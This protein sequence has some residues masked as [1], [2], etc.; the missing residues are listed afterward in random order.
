M[1]IDEFITR[2]RK[3][4]N[5]IIAVQQGEVK[6]KAP[7][8]ALTAAIIEEIKQ[9][10]PA[11][12]EFYKTID[13][14]AGSMLIKQAEAKDYYQ[15]S[16][17]Q[18]RLY[19][20][21]RFDTESLAYNVPQV[22]KLTGSIDILKLEGVFKQLIL[23][24][25]ILRTYFDLINGE[26]V[27]KIAKDV[28]F[29]I[30]HFPITESEITDVTG[31]FVRPFDLGIAP[32]IR[33]GVIGTDRGTNLLMVDMHH[34]VTD[35]VSV[36][37]LSTD[38]MA[39]YSNQ[40]LPSLPLQYKD[41][42]EW[43]QSNE[44]KNE[45]EKQH[46]FWL[47]RFADELNTPELPIDF[48]RPA[49]KS[50]SGD[51]INFS[52]SARE[53]KQLKIIADGEDATL[54]MLLLS[55]FNVLLSKLCNQEDVIVGIPVA[56]RNHPALENLLGMFVNTLVLRNKADGHL[57][58]RQ[59]LAEVKR[60]TLACLDHQS[61]PYEDLI[62]Q[63]KLERE[64]SHNPLFDVMFSYQ[65][66]QRTSIEIPGLALEPWY[67]NKIISKFDITLTAFELED[68]VSLN[69]EYCTD[70]FKQ[71]TIEQFITYFKRIVSLVIADVDMKIS[72]IE[73]VSASERRQLLYDS[74]DTR[75]EYTGERNVTTLFE[76]RA[77]LNP[78]N[79]ALQLNGA[80]T[81]YRELNELSERIA[82]Y[83]QSVKAVKPGDLVG[84][85][86]EREMSLL[87]CLLAIWKAGAAYVPI[88]TS[89][90]AE[91]VQAIIKDARLKVVLTRGE[92]IRSLLELESDVEIIDL[93]KELPEIIRCNHS[94]APV[95]RNGNELAYVMYTSGS[96]GTPKGV[97]I[98]HRSLFNYINWA[99]Q[100]YTKG[101]KAGFA[102]YTSISFDLTV[103]SL[104]LPLITG[105]TLFIYPEKEHHLLIEEVLTEDRAS[106]IKLTPA[107]L[108]VIC[109][110]NVLK[111][112]KT[113]QSKTFIVGGEQLETSLAL[114]IFQKFDGRV[115]IFNEYG[116]TEATVGCMI[117]RFDPLEDRSAV[118]I[119]VPARNTSIYLL[120]KFLQ[121]VATGVQGEMYISGDGVAEGYYL[122]DALTREK[123]V[124]NPFVEGE[125]MYRTGDVAVRL[126]NGNIV[127]KGRMD[128][129][130][131]I[132][133]F[134]IEIGEIESRLK[135]YDA[136]EEAVVVATER[137]GDKCLVGYYVAE[138]EIPATLL[139]HFLTERLPEYM[140][141]A[142]FVHLLSL[143]L[144]ING[145][146]NK[147]ALPAPEVTA[148][149]DYV[150]AA[151]HIENELVE[152][153]ADILRIGKE[154]ISTRKSFFE[155]GG[156]SL[157]IIRL[158]AMIHDRLP[159][160]ITIPEL[161]RYPTIASLTDF[162][163]H[164]KKGETK[165]NNS[166]KEEI[167]GMEQLLSMLD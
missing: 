156:N 125:K 21:H 62:D 112:Y 84:V 90:P 50:F 157:K 127:Y 37:V 72:A 152:I 8:E 101:E 96:T 129:Q 113:S 63:L 58:F 22:F 134:R 76:N 24:H 115:E 161:F 45:R 144:T 83:L 151:G 4:H 102:L 149:E 107:H 124:D 141:P 56:G 133:G 150:A 69:M 122:N 103:T 88:D 33:I 160:Q 27:Q 38:F 11:I 71:E 99:A 41:Y 31:R 25:E 104:F 166:I 163:K 140:V 82:Y 147:R 78:E 18:Q 105:N 67:N 118:P 164:D 13:E 60:S 165:I 114:A 135:K 19:F 70:L 98:A 10:K 16:F 61:Y 146:V 94:P 92:F 65:N 55:V 35:G 100:E 57:T 142:Y 85:L 109:E 59:F 30:E 119:G 6:I 97:M 46:T 154:K 111:N 15:L 143:P 132:R 14:G 5:I 28:N 167:D 126:T 29:A 43:Q 130:V 91:R 64:T 93:S 116:P 7:R 47:S 131:K 36:N 117:Y 44:Q 77:A 52:L 12:L 120:D 75:F 68:G 138:K 2:L 155:L 108:R 3:E 110:S 121:P 1:R 81:S 153:W 95:Q 48:Q 17:A 89:Y 80:T 39:L 139:R 74:N 49:L 137:N 106:V 51:S 42:A 54:F 32:L 23:R 162:M 86:L 159:W 53:L 128:D 66:F 26:P 123:F 145:K 158:H 79:I 40:R 73:L 34:I 87:P 136:I 20:L 148:G 9:K